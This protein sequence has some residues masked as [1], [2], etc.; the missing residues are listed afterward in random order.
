M[1]FRT[2]LVLPPDDEEINYKSRILLL[3]S[4]FADQIGQR[5]TDCK[6]QT[7]VNPFGTIFNPLSLFE[8]LQKSLTGEPLLTAPVQRDGLFFHYGL[9]SSC[10]AESHQA[11]EL[12]VQQRLQK[13]ADF[14]RTSAELDTW[15]IITLGTGLIYELKENGVAVANCHKM[16][17]ALF[18]KRLLEPAEIVE[19]FGRLLPILPDSCRIILTVSP[20]RHIKDTLPLNAVSKSVLR[21]AAHRICEQ[22]KPRV[23]YFPAYELLLDDLRD[24]RFYAEDMLHPSA[25]ATDYIF[26]KFASVYFREPTLQLMRRWQKIRKGLMHR[27]LQAGSPAYHRFLESLLEQLH[28]IAPFLDVRQ[29]ID[30]L[31]AQLQL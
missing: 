15:V 12:L 10:S 28:E 17:A 9:H 20:V 21:L 31:N 22:H 2:E 3:G 25:Q 24:Y 4:C 18:N 23:R 16:P 8:L 29:E 30:S 11:L 13:T 5:L 6:F 27:P 19:A 7:L 1:E 26:D 14:L